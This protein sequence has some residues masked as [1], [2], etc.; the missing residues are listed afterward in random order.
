MK[1]HGNGVNICVFF[2]HFTDHQSVI[3][4]ACPSSGHLLNTTSYLECQPEQNLLIKPGK[5]LYTVK[6]EMNHITLHIIECN[7][8]E[9]LNEL[10]NSRWKPYFKYIWYTI[11]TGT[12]GHKKLWVAHNAARAS[13]LNITEN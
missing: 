13:H 5:N 12:S 2:V 8:I 4:V 10:S 7:F 1:I 6:S 9:K 3:Y 11:F